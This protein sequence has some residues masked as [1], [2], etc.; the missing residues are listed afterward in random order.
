MRK[1][2]PSAAFVEP[3]GLLCNVVNWQA[4]KTFKKLLHSFGSAIFC[5]R[6]FGRLFEWRVTKVL[7]TVPGDFAPKSCAI[8]FDF[9]FF[10]AKIAAGFFSKVPW[11]IRT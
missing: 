4:G 2:R 1:V 3:S 8:Q 11:R 6:S 5:P 10:S 7:L 9:L